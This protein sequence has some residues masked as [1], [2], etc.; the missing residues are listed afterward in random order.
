MLRLKMIIGIIFSMAWGQHFQV[1][2]SN[3]GQTQLTILSNSITALEVGDEI[4]IF[5]ENAIT[6]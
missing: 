6:N 1:N 3:T 5:D 2:L 4:G